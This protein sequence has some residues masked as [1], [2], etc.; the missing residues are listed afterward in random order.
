[1]EGDDDSDNDEVDDDKRVLKE[2]F[3]GEG[4][5][6]AHKERRMYETG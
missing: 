6:W 3:V 4:A 1:M 2:N 5:M